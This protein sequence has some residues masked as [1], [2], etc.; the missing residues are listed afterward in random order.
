MRTV[1]L[2]KHLN[3][4]FSE[5]HVERCHGVGQVVALGGPDDGSGDD[6]ILQ[7][8]RQC[9]LSH[10]DAASLGDLLYRVDDW[11]VT[12][13]VK[14]PPY[15]VDVESSSVLTPG[16]RLPHHPETIR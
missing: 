16:T 5:V 9:D 10:W 2:L 4:L 7:H 15:R 13:D 8:P 3:F 11:S 12:L 6:R 1:W 14:P